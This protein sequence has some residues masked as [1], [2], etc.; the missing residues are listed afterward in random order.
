MKIHPVILCGGSGTRLW[1][2]SRGDYPKQYLKLTGDHSLMQQTALRLRD[3]AGATAP[4]VVANHEQRFLVAEQL[5]Q[6]GIQPTSIVLEPASRNTAPAI[7]VA[8]MLA[9]RNDDDALL[10]VLPSDHVIRNQA[11]FAATA[12]AAAQVAGDNWLVTFGVPP[13]EPHTGYGYIRVGAQLADHAPAFAVDAFIEKPDLDTARLFLQAG[14]HYWNSGMFMLKASTYLE[15]LRRFAPEI[16]RQAELSLEH[17]TRD[18]DFVRLEAEAFAACPNISVD[19]AVMEQ[20]RQAAVIRASDLGWS[21]IG[22]WSALAE[23]A[24]SD[25]AGNT[26]LGDVLIESVSNAYIRAEHR[27]VAALGVDNIVVVETADAVL[28]AHRDKVQ[29]VRKIV[30]RLNASGRRESVTHRRVVRPW[31]A[32][33]GIDHGERF[34]VKRIVVNPGAQ[35]SLQLHHHR[36][37]HWIVVKGT[38]LV[39]N[40]DK[41]TLLTENQS[42]YIP[43]GATHRL[44]N[45]GKI[46]LELIEVQ[47]GSYLGEDDIVRFEDTYGRAP[48]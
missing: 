8:A 20:T 38:A 40:G 13:T 36:A 47:S 28:V 48:K 10:F 30:E 26:L 25:A 45:P 9:M 42:T 11:T 35:L 24:E 37:E 44:S 3:I 41:E 43:L 31:G 22:S 39:T 7:A 14:G 27:M 18:E 34:Q 17:A 5:R 1:P 19:Y 15:E 4:I 21:D 23:L 6:A 32:Y 2:M 12:Q 33:E 46:P 16:A 29:E